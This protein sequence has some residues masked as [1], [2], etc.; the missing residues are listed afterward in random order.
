M[1]IEKMVFVALALW[2][3]AVLIH[4]LYRASTERPT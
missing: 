4:G 2:M 3:A 1:T